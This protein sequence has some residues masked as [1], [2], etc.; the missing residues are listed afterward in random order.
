MTADTQETLSLNGF[1]ST[2]HRRTFKKTDGRNLY[3]YGYNGHFSPSLS[4][5]ENEIAKGGELRWHPLRREWNIYAPHRQHRTFKPS[6]VENPL[7]PSRLGA[8]PTEIPFSDFE[9]AVFENKFTS[10]HPE[11]PAPDAPSGVRTRRAN[12]A[13][14]VVVF[15]TEAE[16]NLWTIGQ[17]RR[18]LLVATWIDRYA[19]M[20]GTGCKFVYPFENRGDA[21]GV[22]LPHPHGQIYGFPFVPS[23]QASA[24]TAFRDGYSLADDIAAAKETYGVASSGGVTAFCPPFARFPYEV[25]IAPER[26]HPGPWT[27]C[28]EEID[29]FADL[30]GEICRRYD[31]LFETETPYMLSMHAA[32]AG[33]EATF[34]FTA[35]FYPLL[36]DKG[37]L[38]YLA[39][40]EQGTGAFTVDVMP[41]RA[42]DMLRGCAC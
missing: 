20:F 18:K 23:V 11:A 33:E 21:V 2:I 19:A 37:R 5:E 29:A 42:A 32:P 36:R 3:F 6:A 39:S 14:E 12:G 4:D 25:W 13:C 24:A 40:V 26:R 38:K 16:G 15:T 17:D 34:H 8:P 41:E 27:F 7:A 22:T 35:Q 31:E 28:A 30:L 9:I 1:P 10:L